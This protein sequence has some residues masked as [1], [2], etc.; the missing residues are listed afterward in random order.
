MEKTGTRIFTTRLPLP[1]AEKV[2]D[3]SRR[4]ERSK[5]WILQ[6]ALLDWIDREEERTRLT[7]EGLNDIVTGRVVE[8]SVMLD[9]SNSLDSDHPLP[10]PLPPP[11]RGR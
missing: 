2:D 11:A 9:W 10:P 3:I 1:L 6:Q 4:L 7:V 5:G 8:Y